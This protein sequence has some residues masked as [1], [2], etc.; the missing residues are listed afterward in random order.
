ML[1][2]Q[3]LAPLSLLALASASPLKPLT[4][5]G[6]SSCIPT[7][8]ADEIVSDFVS[9]LT[10]FSTDV[11][12]NLLAPNF[13]D[14]SDSIDYLVGAPMGSV[15]FPSPAAFIAG[16]GSQ[17]PIGIDVLA[18]D[19]ITCDGVIV[20]RWTGNVG[21]SLEVKGIDVFYAVQVGSE[22]CVGPSGWQLETVYSEFNS[23]AW[24]VDIGGTCAPPTE[25]KLFKA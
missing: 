11:A 6:Y 4:R 7:G 16:Q 23:A 20:W 18:I 24:V 9:L 8:V 3:I 15:T 21:G 14:F 2:S 12:N 5:R 17:P 19:A 22:D 25:G 1:F 13:T 10:G